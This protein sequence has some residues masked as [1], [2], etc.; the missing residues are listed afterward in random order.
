MTKAVIA[1]IVIAMTTSISFYSFDD[2]VREMAPDGRGVDLAIKYVG[3]WSKAANKF[4][5]DARTGECLDFVSN[6]MSSFS[7]ENLHQNDFTTCLEGGYNGL[8]FTGI[9]E[10]NDYTLALKQSKYEDVR[11]HE[12]GSMVAEFG[13]KPF[14]KSERDNPTYSGRM[15]IK[16]TTKDFSHHNQNRFGKNFLRV[17]DPENIEVLQQ[18]RIQGSKHIKIE[19]IQIIYEL[20]NKFPNFLKTLQSYVYILHSEVV[21]EKH[22]GQY[23]TRHTLRAFFMIDSIRRDYP[24]LA[25]YLDNFRNLYRI[26]AEF[27]SP[28]GH[29]LADLVAASQDDVVTLNFYT[30]D[31]NIIPYDDE[32]KPVYDQE[33]AFTDLD[34]YEFDIVA[35]S[36]INIYGIR[37]DTS[38]ITF[39]VDYTTNE[40]RGMLLA[41]LTDVSPTEVSGKAANVVP[42]WLLELALPDNIDD[43]INTAS[44]RMVNANGGSGTFLRLSWYTD[45]PEDVMFRVEGESEFIDS[46]YTK[47]AVATTK[48]CFRTSGQTRE[49]LK[50]VTVRFL[51]NLLTDLEQLKNFPSGTRDAPVVRD[52]AA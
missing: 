45:D 20:S 38:R 3:A 2:A 46:I 51:R 8:A 23:Y 33:I 21:R 9:H 34:S 14:G 16:V 26:H 6:S 39:H 1:A 48:Y 42:D 5:M 32:K 50:N 19:A 41:R 28:E 22:E 11:K 27:R 29:T 36:H 13:L 35:D 7:L 17:I 12:F 37:F 52:N 25:E 47:F 4:G 44:R 31:G 24:A 49:D 15:D 30:R 40:E 18:R 10:G 43:L